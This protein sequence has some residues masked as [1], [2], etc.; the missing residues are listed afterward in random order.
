MGSTW[1]DMDSTCR[2]LEAKRRWTEMRTSMR[3]RGMGCLICFVHKFAHNTRMFSE[4]FFPGD[5][6]DFDAFWWFA[7]RDTSQ[8][9]CFDRML[10]DEILTSLSAGCTVCSLL[11]FELCGK[12]APKQRGVK[13][14]APKQPVRKVQW[15]CS[16]HACCFRQTKSTKGCMHARFATG[17][18]RK[19][20]Q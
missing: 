13:G 14:R 2:M 11:S 10:E 6:S 17:K 7:V 18:E 20:L 5:D 15:N 8:K 12:Q 1:G 3:R 19:T 9:K 16:R 4:P